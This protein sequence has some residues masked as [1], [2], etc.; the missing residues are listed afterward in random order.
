M[1]KKAEISS[2]LVLAIPRFIFLIIVLFSVVLLIKAFVKEKI[3]VKE[4]ESSI[5]FQRVLFGKGGIVWYDEASQ[6]MHPGT[7]DLERFR[8]AGNPQTQTNFLDNI[9]ATYGEGNP[10]L[11]AHLVLEMEGKP[12]L[13][14]Y[15]N[16]QNYFRWEPRTLSTVT[17]GSASVSSSKHASYVLVKDG[18]NLIPAT[19]KATILS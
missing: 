12:P 6:R 9:F 13:E 1:G 18:D 7:I 5:F 11:A 10:I 14:A 15:Y 16:K 4:L 2:E 3:E 19:L 8:E 17:G